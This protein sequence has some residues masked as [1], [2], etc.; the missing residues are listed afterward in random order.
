MDLGGKK[1]KNN[2]VV[3][4]M[5]PDLKG[6][7]EFLDKELENFQRIC[8]ELEKGEKKLF[9]LELLHLMKINYRAPFSCCP[10]R[11]GGFLR[12]FRRNPHRRRDQQQQDLLQ[13]DQRQKRRRTTAVTTT[14]AGAST[15]T[16]SSWCQAQASP[17]SEAKDHEG[18]GATADF[19]KA[20]PV[21]VV[22]GF[23]GADKP[24]I[25]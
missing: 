17:P 5:D 21:S 19:G 12:L 22:A 23:S 9:S 2:V 11:G 14:A 16:C 10:R 13:H 6:A 8:A 20:K 25:F 3:V 4:K 18:S 24:V 7:W 15:S 1:N